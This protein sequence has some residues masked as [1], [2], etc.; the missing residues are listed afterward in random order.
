MSCLHPC[1]H[2]NLFTDPKINSNMRKVVAL[3][4]VAVDG[5][6][7]KL[8]SRHDPAFLLPWMPEVE[9]SS[10]AQVPGRLSTIFQ[11]P[12][13]SSTPKRVA[14]LGG[15]AIKRYLLLDLYVA[16]VKGI[17]GATPRPYDMLTIAAL[18]HGV[19]IATSSCCG[20]RILLD[21]CHRGFGE[22]LGL[23]RMLGCGRP[24]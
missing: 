11:L 16:A 22:G 19:E 17:V 13:R 6:C 8:L 18:R 15:R 4:E 3:D 21:N 1:M 5:R 10:R 9:D 20:V 12:W 7:Y 24:I 23:L 2:A 14:T